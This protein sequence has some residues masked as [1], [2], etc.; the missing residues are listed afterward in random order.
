MH[1]MSENVVLSMTDLEVHFEESSGLMQYFQ[2]PDI[3]RAVDGVNLDIYENDV[4]ALVGESGC[5]KTTLGKTA[6]GLQKPTGGQ[7]KFRGQDLWKGDR[8]RNSS[9][10]D[11]EIRRS[12]QIIH[13]DPGSSINPNHTVMK[14]LMRPLRKWNPDLSQDDY[15]ARILGMLE[16]VGMTPSGDYADRYPHQL[17]GG[18]QQRVALVRALLLNPE[19]I[20]ADEAVSALDVS[21]RIEMM[22]LFLSLQEEFGTSFI[23][24]SHDLSNARYLA[25]QSEGR[26][27]VMYLGEIVEIG[28]A[29]QIINNPQHPYTKALKWS[30]PELWEEKGTD[31][32][33]LRKI[34]IPDPTDPPSGCRFHTRCPKAREYCVDN[35]PAQYE[36]SDWHQASCYR[37]HEE[38]DYWDTPKLTE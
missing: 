1:N 2:E 37:V 16:R 31:E 21:L 34:D 18:E 4:I 35:T 24:I 27:G 3:V 25:Q 29:D 26:I 22:E 7:I 19:L 14:S 8:N 17:S 38:H 15:E 11:S 20:L 9:I 30:T 32:R 5:G 12:L 13:Q 36:V 23:F 6:I 10:S 33:P 28:P